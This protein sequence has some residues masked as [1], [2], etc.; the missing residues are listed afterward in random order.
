MAD[1]TA[2]ELRER[3]LAEPE[4]ILEDRDLMRALIAANDRALGPNVID[5][6]SVAMER[7]ESELDRLEDTHRHVI[8]AAY[9]NLAGTRI[10]QRAVLKLLEPG[11]FGEFLAILQE[12]AREILRL[13]S[14]R[15][16][17]EA[18]VEAETPGPLPVLKIAPAGFCD[19]YVSTGRRGRAKPVTL[20][21]LQDSGELYDDA[22]ILSEALLLLDLGPGRLP[23]LLALGSSDANHFRS[24]HGTEL[25]T[26]LAG[27][28]ERM[29]RRWL[30]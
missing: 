20:R 1:N 27:A 15:L 7:L 8:A 29:M 14:L 28:F 19:A 16:V 9:D 22:A 18:E 11:D 17:I 3:I 12:E 6:R 26:F 30:A 2:Q 13:D 23:G 24:S 21:P 4:L 25:L 5:L 10:V